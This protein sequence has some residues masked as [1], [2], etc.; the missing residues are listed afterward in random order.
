MSQEVPEVPEVATT[1]YLRPLCEIFA[2]VDGQRVF[3]RCVF[4]HVTKD[5]QVFFGQSPVR[6]KDLTGQNIMESLKH[7]PDE[8][9]YPKFTSNITTAA[10]STPPPDN[11][12]VKGPKL[13]AYDS[14]NVRG[15][16]LLSKL[17]LQEVEILETLLRNPHDSIVRYHGCLVQRGFV[18]GMVLDRY[19]ATLVQRLHD[20]SRPFDAELCMAAISSGIDHLH[21]FGLAHNDLTPMNILVGDDDNVVIADLGSCQPFG[22]GLITG[23]SYGWT[24]EYFTTSEQKHD[25]VGL[26]KIRTWLEKKINRGA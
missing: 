9:I 6:K 20:Q 5:Y 23:G 25:T 3:S 22:K 15:T 17:L 14:K 8:D 21:S 26:G 19:P 4:A 11:F 1:R 13:D 7:V 12:F 18:V 24:D 16:G 2:S 10:A